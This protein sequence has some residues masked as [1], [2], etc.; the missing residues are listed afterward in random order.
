MLSIECCAC[1]NGTLHFWSRYP[2]NE[3][4]KELDLLICSNCFSVYNN[5]LPSSP[6]GVEEALQFDWLKSET[7]FTIEEVQRK[8]LLRKNQVEWVEGRATSLVGKRVLDWGAGSGDLGLYLAWLPNEVTICDVD[9]VFFNSHSIFRRSNIRIVK[10]KDLDSG[11]FDFIF[12]WHVLEHLINPAIE[13]RRLLRF[14]N[15]H[16]Y[17]VIQ[18]PK[19]R[20]EDLHSAHH[21]FF[22]DTYFEKLAVSENLSVVASEL[23]WETGYTSWILEKC[24]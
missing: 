14:L 24:C 21:W 15:P 20:I 18:V 6:V 2:N 10:N 7:Y 9:T 3:R 12:A 11:E 13:I 19:L 17:L 23:E 8:A 16:G 22:S 5:E 4:T 1:E